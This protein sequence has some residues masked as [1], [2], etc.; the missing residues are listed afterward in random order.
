MARKRNEY[1]LTYKPIALEKWDIPIG[2]EYLAENLVKF[3]RFRID[4]DIK[5]NFIRCQHPQ[6]NINIIFSYRELSDPALI[7][8]T[9]NT[10]AAAFA[11]HYKGQNLAKKTNDEL[12]RLR[13][14]MKSQIKPS[15]AEE[16]KLARIVVQSAEPAV[17][18]LLLAERT[19]VFISYSH[20]VGDML[21]IESWQS[22]GSSS[23]LQTTD[24]RVSAVFVSCGGN[25]LAPD[26]QH[27]FGDAFRAIARACVRRP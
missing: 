24:G 2:L 8:I 19:E 1:H 21:D 16:M 9:K 17:I 3:G 5:R 22:V 11:P 7:Q 10:L 26:N 15:L 4:A 13:K 6:K 23:G 14:A 20:T 18:M 27:F 25:P 12:N